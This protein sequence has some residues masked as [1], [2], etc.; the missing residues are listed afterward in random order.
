M[1]LLIPE[2][3]I[4]S[5]RILISACM[6]KLFLTVNDIL[7][8]IKRK[9]NESWAFQNVN[10]DAVA[11]LQQPLR[12]GDSEQELFLTAKSDSQMHIYSIYFNKV[13]G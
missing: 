6:W 12:K 5:L 10:C 3:S 13:K 8:K 4:Y 1:Q 2:I 9:A 11:P 7:K